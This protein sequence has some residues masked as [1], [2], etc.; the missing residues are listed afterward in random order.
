[1]DQLIM[2]GYRP[3]TRMNLQS[4][5]AAYYQFCDK[6]RLQPIPASDVQVTR[7]AVYLHVVKQLLP[8]TIENYLSGLRTIHALAGVECPVVNSYSLKAILKGVK[9][10]NKRPVKKALAIDP[11]IFRALFAQ[12]DFSS[13]LEL[14]AWVALLMGFHLLLRAS[15]LT[16]SSRK[17]FNPEVNLCRRD[18]RMQEDIML[19]HIKWSKTL[20]YKE[21]K[22]LIPVLS[23]TEPELSAVT[24]FK[25]M[26]DRIPAQPQDPAFSVP[27]KGNN[28]PLSYSQ[29]ARLLHKWKNMAG[30][31]QSAISCHSLR[32]GG[33]SWLDRHLVPDR[34]I[35]VLGDWKTQCF[36]QYIDSALHTRLKAMEA[37]AQNN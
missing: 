24:W 27:V 3:G 4:Q 31:S 35:Q 37:F 5:A 22:L 30:L 19:V 8:V 29:L 32:R 33:A 28:L 14:V 15:N 16:S 11:H 34:V 12:V 23:F 17:H 13:N 20:Q 25:I 7:F 10:R 26:I 2:E 21:K 9:A 6:Y 18:F 36:K 1:M